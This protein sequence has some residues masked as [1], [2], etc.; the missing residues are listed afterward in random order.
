MNLRPG[1]I[2]SVTAGFSG[3]SVAQTSRAVLWLVWN[4]EPSYLHAEND[5]SP[6]AKHGVLQLGD[7]FSS[8][9]HN[10]CCQPYLTLIPLS[11]VGR[12]EV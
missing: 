1:H 3:Q 5:L 9:G 11:V 8:E 6:V 2:R 4:H 12:V 7:K 10:E